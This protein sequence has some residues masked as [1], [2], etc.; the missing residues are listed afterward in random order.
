MGFDIDIIIKKR[1]NKILLNRAV[2]Q[3]YKHGN[4]NGED[5]WAR[6]WGAKIK[7]E[8]EHTSTSRLQNT[9]NSFCMN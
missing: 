6:T 7:K 4:I 2:I 1:T 3:I 9:T 8:T 5:G